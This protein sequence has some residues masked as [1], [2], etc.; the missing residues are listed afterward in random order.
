MVKM[1]MKM[2]MKMKNENEKHTNSLA[3]SEKNHI[4]GQEGGLL[5]GPS[6][7]S[8]TSRRRTEEANDGKHKGDHPTKK[9]VKECVLVVH[10]KSYSMIFSNKRLP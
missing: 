9:E 1:K 3:L 4:L 2:K 6:L 7:Y 8:D 5:E 10:R